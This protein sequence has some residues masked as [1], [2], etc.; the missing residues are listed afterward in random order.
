MVLKISNLYVDVQGKTLLNGINLNIAPGDVHAIMGPNGSGTSTL[1]KVL[2]G[3]PAYDV[4]SGTV[5]FLGTDLL[6]LTPEQRA[7]AG[8]F[9]SFQYPVEIPGVVNLQFLKASVNAIRS[10]QKKPLL[11]AMDFL[12]F[13]REKCTAL[14]MDEALLYRGVNEGFSGGEKKRN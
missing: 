10:A 9:M 8:L 14:G 13:I 6:P 7:A 5:D 11:D 3:H 1:S 12:R 2:A 4:T